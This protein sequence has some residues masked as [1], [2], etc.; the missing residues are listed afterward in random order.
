MPRYHTYASADRD[1]SK[2]PI[3]IGI[4]SAVL[5][6][7]VGLV[8]L[9][10]ARLAGADPQVVLVI[11]L[12]GSPSMFGWWA[13][14]NRG[15]REQWWKKTI[16]WWPGHRLRLSVIPNLNGTWAGT[17]TSH[18]AIN[19]LPS[20]PVFAIVM[21]YQTLHRIQF[22]LHSAVAVSQS[23]MAYIALGAGEKAEQ[24][25]S[26]EF[27][28]EAKPQSWNGTAAESRFPAHRGLGDYELIRYVSDGEAP[29]DNS[30]RSRWVLRGRYFTDE[31][32]H[33]GHVSIRWIMP[34]H[35]DSILSFADLAVQKSVAQN[36]FDFDGP[37]EKAFDAL[38]RALPESWRRSH[39]P[40]DPGTTTSPAKADRTRPGP[41]RRSYKRSRSIQVSRVA[42]R[43]GD[44][45]LP[46][47]GHAAPGGNA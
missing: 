37:T 45:A 26:A 7:L 40:C 32:Q 39:V 25:V 6:A 47:A 9:S 41:R 29:L 13:L 11:G 33:T 34:E 1:R 30:N 42:G 4:L 38:L 46:P 36:P 31:P 43:A 23:R 35:V 14:I 12:I 19:E 17:V 3:Y 8:V 20:E 22:N 28:Y 10:I 44:D 21:I 27:E 15:Y 24:T 18:Q 5:W 2:A 16:P